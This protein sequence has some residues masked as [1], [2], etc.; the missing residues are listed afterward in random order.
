VEG[1]LYPRLLEIS[2]QLVLRETVVL[3]V[4]LIVVSDV[5]DV[6]VLLRMTLYGV[7]VVVYRLLLLLKDFELPYHVRNT[8]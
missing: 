6:V 5:L 1:G 2:L 3:Y 4:L 8:H 7:V